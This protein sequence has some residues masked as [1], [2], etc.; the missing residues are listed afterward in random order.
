MITP[1]TVTETSVE[2][3]HHFNDIDFAIDGERVLI[4]VS[5]IDS[6]IIFNITTEQFQ[7]LV[8]HLNKLVEKING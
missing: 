4:R 6:L 7:E 1:F 2:F 5:N 8:G 3:G